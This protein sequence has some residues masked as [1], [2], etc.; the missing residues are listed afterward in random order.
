MFNM[1]YAFYNPDSFDSSLVINESIVLSMR[2][3]DSSRDFMGPVARM[4]RNPGLRCRCAG[5]ATFN[6]RAENV[7]DKPTGQAETVPLDPGSLLNMQDRKA[8]FVNR[9]QSIARP[10]VRIAWKIRCPLRGVRPRSASPRVI[11]T[12]LLP[13]SRHA[14]PALASGHLR[15]SS[16][17]GRKC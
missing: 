13:P 15:R 11:S 8:G 1:A 16:A 17:D 3:S 5:P 10:S 2:C 7:A 9:A 12:S 4:E 14:N 6:A